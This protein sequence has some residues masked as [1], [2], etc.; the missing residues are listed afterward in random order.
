MPAWLAALDAL[1]LPSLATRGWAEQFGRVLVEAM[2]CGVPVVASRSGEIPHVVGDAG[3][4][5]EEGDAGA[6]RAALADLAADEVARRRLACAGRARVLQHF[7]QAGI[8]S[9]TLDF[10]REILAGKAH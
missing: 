7:T 9:R 4:L 6:L 5:V 8:A 2:A 1:A 10:Y 3:V